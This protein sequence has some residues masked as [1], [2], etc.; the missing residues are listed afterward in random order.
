MDRRGRA[1]ALISGGLDSC[2]AA[3]IAAQA[4]HL[5]ALHAD[6]GQRTEARERR[7]FE[8]IAERLGA[9]HVRVVDLRF[10]AQIGGSSLLAGGPEVPRGGGGAAGAA[11]A[12]GPEPGGPRAIPSTYVPFRNGLLLSLAVAWAEA[13]GAA[14]IYLGAMEQ[15]SSGYPDCRLSFLRA[16]EKAANQGTRPETRVRIVAPLVRLT[17]GEVVRRGAELGAPLELTWSCYARE[18]VACGTCDSCQIRRRGFAE[19]GVPD[20]AA[21]PVEGRRGA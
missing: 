6:Y 1:V 9:E 16:F 5:C 2:V 7:A 18:D 10:L 8:A 19:A 12:A 11:A 3:T 15:D 20:P 13:L 21:A 17:K 4:H 14:A